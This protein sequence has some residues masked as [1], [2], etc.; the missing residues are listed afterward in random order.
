MLFSLLPAAPPLRPPEKPA[1][2]RAAGEGVG[3]VGLAVALRGR[4]R[5]AKC[6]VSGC[7]C[8]VSSPLSFLGADHFQNALVLPV[9]SFWDLLPLSRRRFPRYSVTNPVY[10]GTPRLGLS[11]R[12]IA[13]RPEAGAHVCQWEYHITFFQQPPYPSSAAG[14]LQCRAGRCYSS[15]RLGAKACTA[16]APRW[17]RS[18]SRDQ[19]SAH[20]STLLNV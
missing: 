1:P 14:P 5:A 7:V 11:C 8:S 13:E 20:G 12:S 2:G 17:Q 19:V 4:R 16:V 9:G 15:E 18:G 3:G 10:S 6:C